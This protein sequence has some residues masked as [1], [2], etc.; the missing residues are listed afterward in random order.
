MDRLGH[1]GNRKAALILEDGTVF[2]G[3]SFGAFHRVSGEVVFNT[4]MY[5]YNEALT[6]P[7]YWGQI[8]VYTY[9]LIGNYGVPLLREVDS[10]GLP[11]WFESSSIKVR[12]LVV[13]EEC[14]EP[15]HWSSALTLDAWLNSEGIPGIWG[16]DTRA[17]TKR[18]RTRGVML[19]RIEVFDEGGEVDSEHVSESALSIEDPNRTD[20]VAEVSCKEPVIY[21]DGGGAGKPTVALIDCGA[22]NS[23]LR[24]MLERGL[25]VVKVPFDSDPDAILE[26]KPDGFMVS[27]GPGDPKIC[28][29][30][31]ETVERLLSENLPMFSICLGNQIFAL[32][33]GGSTYKLKFGHRSVNSPIID[34]S[35]GRCYIS[36]A[37]HGFAVDPTSL[38]KTGLTIS[39]LNAN[40][41]TVEGVKHQSK[42]AM[43]IQHHPEHTPGPSE[44]EF[45]FDIFA[46]WIRKRS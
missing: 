44:L 8:L 2:Q 22:K 10:W 33:L 37:N 9:P 34:L 31:I 5:G 7:S 23:I 43:S 38:E 30:T 15:S 42:R 26:Y 36:S 41:K 19:G 32:A 45:L 1:H 13:H 6:D 35:S 27:N 20:L 24:K 28:V 46:E 39:F 40:D 17:L 3:F 12:G 29:R 18:L 14:K 4:A 16:I 21:G 25:R 11:R